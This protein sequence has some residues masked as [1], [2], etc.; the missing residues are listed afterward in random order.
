NLLCKSVFR[1]PGGSNPAQAFLAKMRPPHSN[2][3][4]FWKHLAL[5]VSVLI[6]CLVLSI[7]VAYS[8]P[9]GETTL[10]SW[11][12][13]ALAVGAIAATVVPCLQVG[14]GLTKPIAHLV[15]V[16]RSVTHGRARSRDTTVMAGQFR[17]LS[18]ALNQMIDIRKKEEEKLKLAQQSL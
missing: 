9:R 11:L 14:R 3:F 16:A 10:Q 18:D 7:Y 15:D 17:E 13:I 12:L 1:E 5:P 8:L 6:G 2:T 4:P